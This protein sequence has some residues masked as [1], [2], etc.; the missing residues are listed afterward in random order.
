MKEYICIHNTQRGCSNILYIYS[1]NILYIYSSNILY[2]YTYI[3]RILM[4]NVY[5]P[6]YMTC[7]HAYKNAQSLTYMYTY[8]YLKIK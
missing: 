5:I 4:N 7:K 8:S 3:N 6:E 2:M 1:S